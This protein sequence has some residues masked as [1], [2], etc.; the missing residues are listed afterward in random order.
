VTDVVEADQLETDP[1]GRT[2]PGGAPLEEGPVDVD[3]GVGFEPVGGKVLGRFDA[4]DGVVQSS[5]FVVGPVLEADRDV[6]AGSIVD[7]GGL[8]RTQREAETCPCAVVAREA[9]EKRAPAAPDVEHATT[10]YAQF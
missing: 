3:L 5:R 1:S 7:V 9:V 2:E 8:R 4:C 6:R 10:A